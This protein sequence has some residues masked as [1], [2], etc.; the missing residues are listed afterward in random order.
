MNDQNLA[1]LPVGTQTREGTSNKAPTSESLLWPSCYQG[2]KQPSE[3][4][5]QGGYYLVTI[6]LLDCSTPLAT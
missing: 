4:V 1:S 6:D 3:E 2:W 5:T